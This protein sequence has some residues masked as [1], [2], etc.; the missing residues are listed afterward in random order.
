MQLGRL[1]KIE[2]L[3]S[4]ENMPRIRASF[5]GPRFRENSPRN[6]WPLALPWRL[7]SGG[8]EGSLLVTTVNRDLHQPEQASRIFDRTFN[9]QD[10]FV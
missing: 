6:E 10:P 5:S 3:R 1:A 9:R 8:D 7:G 4:P 2:Y